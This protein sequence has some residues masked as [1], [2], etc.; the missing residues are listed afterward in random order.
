MADFASSCSLATTGGARGRW[1][2]L[3]CVWNGVRGEE[4]V[5]LPLELVSE[6]LWEEEE[7]GGAGRQTNMLTAERDRG[8][9]GGREECN[10]TSN[11]TL[12]PILEAQST[13][14]VV[15]GPSTGGGG[16]GL[17]TGVWGLI[18]GC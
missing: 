18:T 1:R 13:G 2:H 9:E 12:G 4:V 15:S 6:P 8:R 17:I 7:G 5:E 11:I 14:R 16:L 10:Q 3:D